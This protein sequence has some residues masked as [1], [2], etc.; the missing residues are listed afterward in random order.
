VPAASLY[1][2]YYGTA[3]PLSAATG[4]NY[5]WVGSRGTIFSDAGPIGSTDGEDEAPGGNPIQ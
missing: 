1:S 4:T 3:T 2:T 5:Y